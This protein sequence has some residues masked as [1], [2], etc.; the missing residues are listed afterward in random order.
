MAWPGPSQTAPPAILL[1]ALDGQGLAPT[2]RALPTG[3]DWDPAGVL[4]FQ[5]PAPD[6]SPTHTNRWTGLPGGSE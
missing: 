1:P 4:T 2:G 6:H 5:E 3:M